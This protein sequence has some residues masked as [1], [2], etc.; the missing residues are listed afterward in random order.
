MEREHHGTSFPNVV[1]HESEPYAR[2]ITET[3]VPSNYGTSSNVRAYCTVPVRERPAVATGKKSSWQL[4]HWPRPAM[5]LKVGVR[6]PKIKKK[7]QQLTI[8]R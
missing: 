2:K 8:P 6:Q 7:I 5:G 1:E 3:S 4:I